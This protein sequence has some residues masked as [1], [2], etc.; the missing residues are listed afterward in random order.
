[1]DIK[2][3]LLQNHICDYLNDLFESYPTD[4]SKLIDSEAIMILD[5]IKSIICN[6]KLSDFDAVE[7]IVL[8]FEE[9]NIDCGNRHDF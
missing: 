8:T 7:Q 5:K 9:Y 6:D 4:T 3:E 2:L 1:M